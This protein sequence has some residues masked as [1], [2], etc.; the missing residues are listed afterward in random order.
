MLVWETKNLSRTNLILNIRFKNYKKNSGNFKGFIF[1]SLHICSNL[2]FLSKAWTYIKIIQINCI[3]S[4]V[5]SILNSKI[6]R[7]MLKSVNVSN[8]FGFLQMFSCLKLGSDVFLLKF[9]FFSPFLT[10]A[11]L[12]LPIYHISL[13]LFKLK[14]K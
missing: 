2:F 10:T 8:K 7:L 4:F 12:L 3:I 9:A 1:L 6:E 14:I 13:L 5:R 11:I